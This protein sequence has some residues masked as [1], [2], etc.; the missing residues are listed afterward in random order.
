VISK[1]IMK[2]LITGGGQNERWAQKEFYELGDGHRKRLLD[3]GCGIGVFCRFYARR[4]FE[5]MP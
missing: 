5:C 1:I 3:A 2:I 4:G